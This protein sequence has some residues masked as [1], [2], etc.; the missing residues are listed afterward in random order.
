MYV[1]NNST[2]TAAQ[3][4]HETKHA[5]QYFALGGGLFPFVPMYF[6]QMGSSWIIYQIKGPRHDGQG[7]TCTTANAC[8]NFFE[9]WAGLHDG[10]YYK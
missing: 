4:Q 1:G 10:G 2:P 5:S 8:Y 7:R 9:E 6:E 3:M